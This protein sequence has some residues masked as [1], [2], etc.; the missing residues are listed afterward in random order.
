LVA[1]LSQTSPHFWISLKPEC[2]NISESKLPSSSKSGD[3]SLLGHP[4]KLLVGEVEG[5]R[6]LFPL[7]S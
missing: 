4:F 2:T 1:Q 6:V 5:E 7:A 3:S